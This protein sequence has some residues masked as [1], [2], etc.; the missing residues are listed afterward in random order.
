MEKTGTAV[1]G[2]GNLLLKDEGVGIHVA[3]ALQRVEMPPHVSI[4][5]GGTS[6]D[7]PHYL[8]GTGKV[9]I[10]DAVRGGGE[11]GAVYRFH[12]GDVK[13]ETGGTSSLHD[14]G[15]EQSL[16]VMK[17]LGNGPEEVVIIGVEPGEIGWGTELSPEVQQKIP[18]IIAAV[19]N[20]IEQ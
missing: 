6:L 11:P 19:R 9:I 18:E 16:K 10:V 7:L 17:L 8:E 13:I 3:R 5:D 1:V 20:E 4:I 14:L 12:P 2:V 15:L